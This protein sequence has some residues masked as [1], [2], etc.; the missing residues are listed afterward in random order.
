MRIA[1]YVRVRMLNGQHTDMK[2]R[3][4]REYI[5]R[6]RKIVG[7]YIDEGISGARQRRPQLDR[8]H[9]DC[10]KRKVDAV[11]AYRN[12][13]FARS[14]R[15]LVSALETFRGLNIEFV[16]IHQGAETSTP[17]GIRVWNSCDGPRIRAGTG[18][19]TGD[20]GFSGCEEQKCPLLVFTNQLCTAIDEYMGEEE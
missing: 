7:E 1:L 8:R 4:P 9:V 17:N 16:R 11:L 18:E 10:P 20:F 5:H 13:R 6:R 12:D 15:H 19:V 2:L 14:L 3:E